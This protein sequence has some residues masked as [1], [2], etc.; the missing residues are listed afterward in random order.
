ME[1]EEVEERSMIIHDQA[2]TPFS[3]TRLPSV[4]P[5]KKQSLTNLLENSRSSQGAKD[6]KIH[7]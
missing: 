1:Q 5:I 3:N 7:K 2:Q 4:N 6:P